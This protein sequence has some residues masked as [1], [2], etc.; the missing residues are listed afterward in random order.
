MQA[1]LPKMI[2]FDYGHT[3][4]YEP[5]FDTLRGIRALFPYIT[6][7]PD[8]L[9]PE[10][11]NDAHEAIFAELAPVRE[12]GVEPHEWPML[13]FSLGY[14]GLSLS[15]PLGEAE[16]IFWDAA[17]FGAVMPGAAEML[18]TLAA[19]GI[20]SGVVSN[21]GFSGGAL[22]A[23]IGRLLPRH[24]FEFILASSEYVFRK[25]DRRLF[26]LALRKAGLRAGEAWFC[27]DNVRADVE[28]A[29][30]AGIFPVWYDERRVE[31]LWAHP[32][33]G[34][35]DCPHLRVRSWAEFT[36]MLEGRGA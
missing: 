13:R 6:E 9:T 34:V 4:L 14:L 36:G 30:G 15:V 29:A 25:P 2:L 3:L 28:G 22:E 19:L 17:S 21:I 5:D 7:N 8:R 11:V 1:Q 31:N 35:P 12:A 33:D 27:G 26:A 32:E 18:D 23:R 10:R 16:R 20:R 24:R